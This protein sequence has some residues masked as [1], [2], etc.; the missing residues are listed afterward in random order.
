MSRAGTGSSEAQLNLF[1]S[2]HA[3]LLPQPCLCTAKRSESF[4]NLSLFMLLTPRAISLGVREDGHKV[5]LWAGSE[6]LITQACNACQGAYI[7]IVFI[8]LLWEAGGLLA[9]G[10]T[11]EETGSINVL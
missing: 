11:H 6:W 4:H 2:F 8:C 1:S 10:F 9:S 5:N 3:A 7:L